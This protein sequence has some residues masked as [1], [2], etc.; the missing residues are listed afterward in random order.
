MPPPPWLGEHR[1]S[2]TLGMSQPSLLPHPAPIPRAMY[3][4]AQ[5]PQGIPGAGLQLRRSAPMQISASPGTASACAAARVCV[6]PPA[7]ALHAQPAA[8]RCSPCLRC[9]PCLHPS[10]PGEA[11]GMDPA[12]MIPIVP[13]PHAPQGSPCP[14]RSYS[15]APRCWSRWGAPLCPQQPVGVRGGGAGWPHTARPSLQ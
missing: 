15:Q 12:A 6:H 13:V 14:S 8:A 9:P 3:L 1:H 5:P 10:N 7:A 4:G 11:Q 2:Q